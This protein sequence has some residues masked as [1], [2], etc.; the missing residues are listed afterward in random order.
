[1]IDTI[2]NK[3]KLN[4]EFISIFLLSIAIIIITSS[5]FLFPIIMSIIISYLLY[6]I[7][8]ILS[9][10]GCPQYVSFIIIYL[11]FLTTFFIIL[12]ILIPLVFKQM[13][14][15]FNDLPFMIQKIKFKTSKFIEKY[16][17]TLSP[18]QTN[19]IFSNII[20]YVQSIGKTIISASLLSIAIIIKWI[21]YIL[22]IPILVF[23]FLKDYKEI[24][25]WFKKI[26]PQKHNFLKK[27]WT[28]TNQQISNYI[29]G[30]FIEL[31]IIV[32]ANYILFKYYNLIYS[33]LLA[34]AVGISVIIPY[35]GA[36]IVSI[37][38]I[39]I[40]IVQ[41]GMTSE[42]IYLIA[43]YITI[44]FIDGNLL[45]PIL[46]SEAVNL[47][48]LSIMISIIIFGAI[49][50]LYGVFLAIPLAIFLK[51]IIKIYLTPNTNITINNKIKN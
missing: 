25:N 37:P 23:F 39:F 12:F 36:I 51:A 24:I 27:I 22:L 30:K 1:M 43:I 38:I 47:H 48:P 40:S 4:K 21:L 50:N 33:D 31:I 5:S 29:R 35:I 41:F 10:C 46:F 8:K 28:A 26:M 19:L 15:L 49:F 3:I 18:E 17:S 14:G 7:I 9:T 32:L 11:L 6:N 34:I 44:Q 42:F 45:V 20:S 13:V 2:K 16:P